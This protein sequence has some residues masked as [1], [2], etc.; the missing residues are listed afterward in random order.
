[1]ASSDR[2]GIAWTDIYPDGHGAPPSFDP[3]TES[4][5]AWV[6]ALLAR[7]DGDDRPE[8]VEFRRHGQ[9]LVDAYR[10]DVGTPQEIAEHA[11]WLIGFIVQ[12]GQRV[13][14]ILK[15]VSDSLARQ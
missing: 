11:A 6:E 3:P 15:E 14:A 9:A 10:R 8:A 12:A 7:A 4:S 1:M 13:S 5:V 2:G